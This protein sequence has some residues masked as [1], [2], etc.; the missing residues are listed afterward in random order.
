MIERTIDLERR[1]CKRLHYIEVLMEVA[2]DL[3][4]PLTYVQR[5]IYLLYDT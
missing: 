1:I 5:N 2:N 4:T 3:F